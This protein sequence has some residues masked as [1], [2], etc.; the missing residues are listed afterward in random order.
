M[1]YYA[2]QGWVNASEQRRGGQPTN[3]SRQPPETNMTEPHEDDDRE[4]TAALLASVRAS[5]QAERAAREEATAEPPAGL[6]ELLRPRGRS[7]PQSIGRV[8]SRA[9]AASASTSFMIERGSP[10]FGAATCSTAPAS[11]SGSSTT[12][13]ARRAGPTR[14]AT[15]PLGAKSCFVLLTIPLGAK[16]CFVSSLLITGLVA[17]GG[18]P[19][20]LL[21]LQVPGHFRLH[22]RPLD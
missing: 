17:V 2:K 6:A 1:P 8:P 12:C 14:S 18:E 16:S 13:A 11:R 3:W 5:I 7:K 21:G 19:T 15:I 22:K 20:T 4:R 10:N 9:S